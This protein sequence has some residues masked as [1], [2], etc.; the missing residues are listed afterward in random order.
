M[1]PQA[2]A[3]YGPALTRM[4][5]HPHMPRHTF[6]TDFYRDAKNLR[7]VQKALG[8]SSIQATQIYTHIID[9]ELENGMKSFRN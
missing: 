6:G 8:H 7:M 2:E 1:P 4:R 9:D 5:V 3:A